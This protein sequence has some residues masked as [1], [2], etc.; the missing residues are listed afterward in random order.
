MGEES[1]VEKKGLW[2]QIWVYALIAFSVFMVLFY[3]IRPI[4]E[5]AAADVTQIIII[6]FA[7]ACGAVFLFF[8]HHFNWFSTKT[9]QMAVS[10]AVGF[11]LWT[12]AESIFFYYNK[13]GLE[14]FPT[15]A[16]I[17]Y[18]IGYIPFAM[19]LY[20]NIRT[21]VMKFKPAVRA[22]WIIASVAIFV[23][24]LFYEFIPFLSDI[25]IYSLM[26]LYPLEAYII[27]VLVLVIV[28]K[29]RSG[30]IAKPWALLA[31][32]FILDAIGTIWDTYLGYFDLSISAYDWYDLCFNLS[33]IAWF[34][35]GLYFIWLYKGR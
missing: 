26:V 33:Y 21:V 35:S 14:L 15:P 25:T 5:A 12:I 11:I 3:I 32:G 31:I 17:F 24:I 9:G 23:V 4:E 19:A 16:D 7:A 8:A 18:F 10:I 1:K 20:L 34:A 28:L 6:A 27:L 29:F 13:L 30:E 22:I 2:S